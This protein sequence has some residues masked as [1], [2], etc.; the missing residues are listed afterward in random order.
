LVLHR[1]IANKLLQDHENQGLLVEQITE[2]VESRREEGRM[3]YGEYLTW[4]S[5]LEM[6]DKP[7]D[8]IDAICEDSTRMRKLR[9]RTPFVGVLTEQERQEALDADSLGTLSDLS[10]LF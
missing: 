9:R 5:A 10:S 1:A 6:I 2:Q 3:G 7:Q 8:F 4:I